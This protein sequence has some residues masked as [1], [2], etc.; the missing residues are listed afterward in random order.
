MN[1]VSNNGEPSSI[2]WTVSGSQQPYWIYANV[3]IGR[4]YERGWRIV[5]DALPNIN[6]DLIFS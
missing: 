1:S 6:T 5:I 3:K 2:L 4:S